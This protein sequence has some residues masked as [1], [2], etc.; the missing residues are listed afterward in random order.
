M[1]DSLT[2]G[3][4]IAGIVIAI[5]A[6]SAISVGASTMLA[7]GPQGLQGEQGETG[8]QGD[9]GP[10]GPQGVAGSAGA[11]GATGPTGPRGS[12]GPAGADG[13]DGATGPQ[14]PQ[15]ERGFGVPQQGNI[16]VG[17]SAFTPLNN[18]DLV[19]WSPTYGLR[20][21]DTADLLC[22]APVQLPHGATVT[23]ATFYFYDNDAGDYFYFY[24]CRENATWLDI[25][26]YVS[27]SPASETP[28]STH[29]SASN[30]DYATVDNNTY[31]YWLYFKLPYS[32]TSSYD[33]RFYYALVEYAYP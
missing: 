21:T 30:I 8:P 22:M 28:G 20:N 24:L 9:T 10:Q 2:M 7:A 29:V 25:M 14:G 26:A 19:N 27:T 31:H 4:F 18:D 3:K 15:G 5:L 6:A 16:S 32:S 12:T 11:T 17:Y 13:A 1:A 23:N 33:Y